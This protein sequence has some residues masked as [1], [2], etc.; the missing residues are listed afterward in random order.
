MGIGLITMA[1]GYL[2]LRVRHNLPEGLFLLAVSVF[3]GIMGQGL[4]IKHSIENL[5]KDLADNRGVAQR[6]W[7]GDLESRDE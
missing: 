2:H 1:I 7:A 6:P 3:S 5:R 4:L